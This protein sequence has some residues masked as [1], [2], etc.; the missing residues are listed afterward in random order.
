MQRLMINSLA[1]AMNEQQRKVR[2]KPL[3]GV[4][5]GALTVF[6]QMRINFKNAT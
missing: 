4:F 3:H 5:C 2:I 1:M 6:K